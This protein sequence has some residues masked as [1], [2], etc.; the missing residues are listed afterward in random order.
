MTD[1]VW[2]WNAPEGYW[3][4]STVNFTGAIFRGVPAWSTDLD[5]NRLRIWPAKAPGA[6]AP[7]QLSRYAVAIAGPAWPGR[8]CPGTVERYVVRG[9]LVDV[10]AKLAA[11]LER[12]QRQYDQRPSTEAPAD[13][14]ERPT[15]PR[16]EAH[17]P[18]RL[19]VAAP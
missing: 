10:R 9:S 12:R 15:P 3:A 4:A 18:T 2:V 7:K 13:E 8:G 19:V 16:S 11:A 6:Q 1:R 5:G 17:T 14:Q